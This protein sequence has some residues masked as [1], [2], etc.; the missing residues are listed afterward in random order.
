MRTDEAEL[1]SSGRVAHLDRVPASVAGAHS[2]ERRFWA[3]VEKGE[4][5]WNWTGAVTSAGYGSIAIETHPKPRMV[6]AHRFAWELA[7]GTAV[8]DGQVVMHSCD[9]RRCVRPDHLNLGTV[10]DN[11]RDMLRKGRWKG[12]APHC[13]I[14]GLPGNRRHHANDA[15]AP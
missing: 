14:C 2:A 8:P 13:S 5:C 4:G 7:N 11:N 1:P 15:V 6:S 10:G 12:G 3:K 9:N